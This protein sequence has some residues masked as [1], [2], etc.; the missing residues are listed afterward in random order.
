MYENINKLLIKCWQYNLLKK[1]DKLPKK[2]SLLILRGVYAKDFS[3]IDSIYDKNSKR[4]FKV[5]PDTVYTEM[6]KKFTDVE[7]WPQFSNLKC[8]NCDQLPDSYPR[9]IPMNLESGIAGSDIC[10]VYGHFDKWNCA[11]NHVIKEFPKDQQWDA[12]RAISIIE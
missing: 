10:D 6:P 12:L 2:T 11:V 9:F 4:E 1:M 7:S 3:P 8:W 5:E